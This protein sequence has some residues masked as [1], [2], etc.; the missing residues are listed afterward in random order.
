VKR[1]LDV[2]AARPDLARYYASTLVPDESFLQTIL[3]NQTDLRVAEQRLSFTRW[4]GSGAAHPK[5]LRSEDIAAALDSGCAFAR[6]FD[7][8]IDATALDALDR[9][10]RAAPPEGRQDERPL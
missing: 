2:M 1:I 5:I 9:A 8:D 6:K 4:A 3:G 7:I 10:T